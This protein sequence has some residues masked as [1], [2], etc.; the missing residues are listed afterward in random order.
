MVYNNLFNEKKMEEFI[1]LY[2]NE[3]II[4]SPEK[5]PV[6]DWIQKLNNNSRKIIRL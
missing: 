2:D 1:D 5:D 4:N 3:L 6:C